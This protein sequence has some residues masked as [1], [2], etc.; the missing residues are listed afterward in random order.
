MCAPPAYSEYSLWLASD[1]W[2]PI[3]WTGHLE[4]FL[5]QQLLN[6]HFPGVLGQTGPTFVFW[7]NQKHRPGLIWCFF[8]FS[9]HKWS[10]I[11][12]HIHL[13][14]C[15]LWRIR[16]QRQ[17][18]PGLIWSDRREVPFDDV[19]PRGK[20]YRLNIS[21]YLLFVLNL[22]KLGGP[23]Y[24]YNRVNPLCNKFIVCCVW[25]WELVSVLLCLIDLFMYA[26]WCDLLQTF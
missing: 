16:H 7:I 26:C 21:S 22:P 9:T 8:Y 12:Q 14:I 6:S 23:V 1:S 13:Q 10:F 20:N 17:H 4:N 11:L 25:S 3:I 5:H 2:S 24:A 18:R 19:W 15:T